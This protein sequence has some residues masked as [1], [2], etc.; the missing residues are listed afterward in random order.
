MRK[1]F[2]LIELLVYIGIIGSVLV[3]AT[4]LLWNVIFG[5]I[6]ENSYQEV[7]QN[8]RFALTK[9]SQEIKKATGINNPAIGFFDDNLSLSM[10]NPNFNPTNFDVFDNKLRMSQGSNQFFLTSDRTIVSDIKFT[11]LSYPGTPGAVRIEMVL[12]HVVPD[13]QRAYLA[14]INS[15]STVSLLPGGAAP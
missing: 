7:Q 6:K 5:N 10:A 2:T 1:G 11:N 14:E 12:S 3:L 15:I 13:N 8:T 4:G 9:M